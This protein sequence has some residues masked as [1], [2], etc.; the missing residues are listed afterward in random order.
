MEKIYAI[1]FNPRKSSY[2]GAFVGSAEDVVN[3]YLKTTGIDIKVAG[4]EGGKDLY[5]YLKRPWSDQWDIEGILYG[6]KGGSEAAKLTAAKEAYFM[7]RQNCSFNDDYQIIQLES[8][9]HAELFYMTA[10]D[11]MNRIS[12]ADYKRYK[13][14]VIEHNAYYLRRWY[15]QT[16]LYYLFV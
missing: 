15:L 11:I 8:P 13:L 7:H 1:Q 4:I 14:Y 3:F 6:Q 5:Y 12:E 16:K 10:E 2:D 9:K